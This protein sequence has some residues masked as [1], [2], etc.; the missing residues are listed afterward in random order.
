MD[1]REYF[2]EFGD[3]SPGE[4]ARWIVVALYGGNANNG[5]QMW[6]SKKEYDEH[7]SG[8]VEKRCK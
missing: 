6:I 1:W 3:V 4:W 2:G 7:G 5:L 8:I